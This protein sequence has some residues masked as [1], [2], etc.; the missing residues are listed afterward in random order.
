[1]A[2]ELL[3]S[4]SPYERSY[5]SSVYLRG[6]A[7]LRL[8]KGAEAVAKFRK[9]ADHRGANW[10]ATW[11]HPYWGQ[12]YS[13]SYLGMARGYVLAGATANA[14]KAFQDFF[15]LWKNADRDIPV[16]KHAQPSTPV[17]G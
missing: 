17:C 13:L 7:Y 9:I 12:F 1:M 16:L 2:V 15:E 5:L 10:G 11:I 14:T 8:D 4:A 3:A 6:L